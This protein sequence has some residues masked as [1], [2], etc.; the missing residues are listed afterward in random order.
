MAKPGRPPRQ[1]FHQLNLTDGAYA[2]LGIV[3]VNVDLIFSLQPCTTTRDMQP[4][5]F[6]VIND[7]IA[8]KESVEDLMKLC[9]NAPPQD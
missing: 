9:R 3:W 4:V 6:T 1:K 2:N 7:S 8:V 5:H